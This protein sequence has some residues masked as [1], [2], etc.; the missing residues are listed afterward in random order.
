M[1]RKSVAFQCDFFVDD[2]RDRLEI[3]IHR[4]PRV[5]AL[6]RRCPRSA[7]I[8]PLGPTA[9]PPGGRCG[10]GPQ[11]R[12]RP[13]DAIPAGHP[14]LCSTLVLRRVRRPWRMTLSGLDIAIIGGAPVRDQ[15]PGA[16][17]SGAD[18]GDAYGTAPEDIRTCPGPN[19]STCCLSEDPE[20]NRPAA[21]RRVAV[22]AN[23][24]W[25]K[26]DCKRATAP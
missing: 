26:A 25:P 8:E 14:T 11:R 4:W 10:E 21:I 12:C 1:V 6:Q 16:H 20:Q 18:D 15:R 24:E 13:D 3:G 9:V 17:A 2:Y 5:A 23:G 22:A 7:V 19:D